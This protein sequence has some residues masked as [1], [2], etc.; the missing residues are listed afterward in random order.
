MLLL[1]MYILLCR[2]FGKEMQLYF[3][4]VFIFKY[5]VLKSSNMFT[6]VF[7]SNI[8]KKAS[9]EIT[10]KWLEHLKE[11]ISTFQYKM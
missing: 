2:K 8:V 11:H 3:M 9:S 6:F 4:H 5:Y 1:N 7:N 10:F